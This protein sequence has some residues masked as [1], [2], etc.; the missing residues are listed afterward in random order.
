M[1]EKSVWCVEIATWSPN[2]MKKKER[3]SQSNIGL[4]RIRKNDKMRDTTST[5]S[6]TFH[7]IEDVL[8]EME[9]RKKDTHS[10]TRK[11]IRK[12]RIEVT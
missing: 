12:L 8:D 4:N 5:I 6:R 3:K 7:F 9:K 1:S 11:K 2:E 10:C